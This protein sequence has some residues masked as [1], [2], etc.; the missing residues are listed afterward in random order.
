MDKKQKNQLKAKS[1]KVLRE[2]QQK[3]D[4]IRDQVLIFLKQQNR[5]KTIQKQWDETK[6]SFYRF[7]E[8]EGV[9]EEFFPMKFN[10]KDAEEYGGTK[11]T[12]IQK[13]KITWDVERLEEKLSKNLIKKVIQKRYVINDMDGLI[14]YLKTYG[15]N[16]NEFK[17][18]LDVEKK[19][20]ESVINNLHDVG[21]ISKK[22]IDGCY[23]VKKENPYWVVNQI[24]K[25]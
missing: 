11:V 22:D 14:R 9:A 21:E 6:K 16:P 8:E 10:K 24:Q 2:E 13:Q 1:K 18:F 15:V 23:S 20:N 7:M 5:F 17:K 25:K 3:K 19:V 4:L 12:K